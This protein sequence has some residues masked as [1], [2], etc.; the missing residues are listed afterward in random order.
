MPPSHRS[1]L[2]LAATLAACSPDPLGPRW[3]AGIRVEPFFPRQPLVIEA[4]NVALP[5]GDSARVVV[6]SASDTELVTLRPY[7]ATCAA[8]GC[9]VVGFMFDAGRPSTFFSN[10][11]LTADW[12]GTL[13]TEADASRGELYVPHGTGAVVRDSVAR[14]T[15]FATLVE[16]HGGQDGLM[17][18]VLPTTDAFVPGQTPSDQPVRAGD[19]VLHVRAG[20]T[21]RVTTG[22]GSTVAATAQTAP[23]PPAPDV[24]AGWIRTG[25]ASYQLRVLPATLEFAVTTTLT[26]RSG[27]TLWRPTCWPVVPEQWTA[28]GWRMAV[29]LL[30]LASG[31]VRPDSIPAGATVTD[32]LRVVGAREPNAY[33]RF[34]V[35]PVPG[36]YRVRYQLYR[37]L[38]HSGI[39]YVLSDPLPIEQRVSNAFALTLP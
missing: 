1:A 9:D 38:T 17:Q 22:G 16:G 28:D 39:D 29:T 33:P 27:G 24:S 15:L 6:T 10:T 30:C 14:E 11:G 26:N 12:H 25:A 36:T 19:G 5:A 3:A 35:D 23:L 18:A 20:E 21:V 32:T 7:P 2:L 4:P 37:T 13:R 31:G 34:E 8:S